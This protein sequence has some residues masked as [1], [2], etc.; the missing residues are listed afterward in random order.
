MKV[1][2]KATTIGLLLTSCG[3]RDE[4][5]STESEGG[6]SSELPSKGPTCACCANREQL[7]AQVR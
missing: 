5:L 1:N 7:G 6:A 2:V 3:A 4:L